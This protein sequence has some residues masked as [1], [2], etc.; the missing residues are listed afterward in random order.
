[1]RVQID[2]AFEVHRFQDIRQRIHGVSV[3]NGGVSART[4]ILMKKILATHAAERFCR[5]FES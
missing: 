5:C 3:K 4:V 2:S 1:L